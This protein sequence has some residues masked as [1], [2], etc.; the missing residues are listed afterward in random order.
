MIKL[1][2]LKERF[3]CI[4]CVNLAE[5]YNIYS[6]TRRGKRSN[7]LYLGYVSINNS[8]VT[9]YPTGTILSDIEE[10]DKIANE[11]A[12]NAKYEVTTYSPDCR[13]SCVAELRIHDFLIGLGFDYIDSSYYVL[14]FSNCYSE[15]SFLSVYIEI[16]DKLEKNY[17]IKGHV[18]IN[19]TKFIDI[20]DND[21]KKVIEHIEHIV[22][23][24]TV[25]AMSEL[26]SIHSKTKFNGSFDDFLIKKLNNRLEIEETSLKEYIIKKLEDTLNKL[27]SN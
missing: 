11:W 8:K 9:H 26:I 4:A 14:N 13:K 19:S 23:I 6:K 17:S 10:F 5:H 24:S 18:D 15:I 27:K 1:K 16:E 12:D 7:N 25:Y 21:Y 22:G 2:D 3:I 20:S